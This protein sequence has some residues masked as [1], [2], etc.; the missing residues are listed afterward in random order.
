MSMPAAPFI[1]RLSIYIWNVLYSLIDDFLN[2]ILPY[3]IMS[4][5]YNNIASYKTCFLYE[6]CLLYYV[7]RHY[8]R[9]NG[10]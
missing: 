2:T 4:T 3:L 6:T 9:T 10:R 8:A 1:S 7:P 5:E